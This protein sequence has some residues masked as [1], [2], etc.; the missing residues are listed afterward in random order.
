MSNIPWNN[1][2]AW[3]RHLTVPILPPKRRNIPQVKELEH[4]LCSLVT[5]VKRGVAAVQTRRAPIVAR[6]PLGQNQ[7]GLSAHCVYTVHS[8]LLQV[9]AY[10][11]GNGTCDVRGVPLGPVATMGLLRWVHYTSAPSSNA[12]VSGHQ[13]NQ[14]SLYKKLKKPVVFSR[15]FSVM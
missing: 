15:R 2:E 8:T 6:A 5:F 13:P 10:S 7:P 4:W 9:Y 3:Q 12:F 14:H 11:Q 1:I